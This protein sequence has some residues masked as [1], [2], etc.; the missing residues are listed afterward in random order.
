MISDLTNVWPPDTGGG[1]VRNP[2][3]K[4]VLGIEDEIECLLL[5]Y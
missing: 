3:L 1:V 4:D 2:S 5:M